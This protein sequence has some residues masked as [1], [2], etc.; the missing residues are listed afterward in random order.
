MAALA[1]IAI[2]GAVLAYVLLVSKSGTGPDNTT[3]A[4][5]QEE[6]DAKLGTLQEQ[7]QSAMQ[8][9]QN[10]SRILA[11]A[12]LFTEDHPEQVPGHILLA[13]LRMRMQEWE[14]AYESWTNALKLDPGVY[15]ICKM[16]GFCA[17]RLGRLNR[18][19]KHYEEAVDAA[20][21]QADN[22]VFASIGQLHLSLGNLDAAEAAFT[23]SLNAPGAGEKTNWKHMGYSGLANVA[24]VRGDFEE[25][26]QKID[27]AIK[28]ANSD[29]NAD[30]VGYNI[31][32][33]RLYLDERRPNDALLMLTTTW[34]QYNEAT[35]RIES[36]RLRAR[37]YELKGELDQ[38][39]NHIAYV[40][41]THQTDPDRQD[42]M[43]ADFYAL[44]AEWQIKAGQK[45]A[46]KTSLQNLKTLEP[47]HPAIADL[48]A[49]LS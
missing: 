2:G 17:A 12:K 41:Q 28:F 42:E 39:V 16:A 20:G 49:S 14:P 36:A 38:A 22:E 3:P 24:A 15:E 5:T 30:I 4:L 35:L 47:E 44:L 37:L 45:D 48:E 25:A 21:D 9:Q 46:A 40:C 26:H 33:A 43:L 10:L 11:R 7:F 1:V 13:Q 27:R 19:L 6:I 23:K 31:Q 8:E 34:Q 32:K 29:S 18:A